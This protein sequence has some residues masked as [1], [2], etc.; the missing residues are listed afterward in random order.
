MRPKASQTVWG[1]RSKCGLH[2]SHH[3]LLLEGFS[4]VSFLKKSSYSRLSNSR[5]FPTPLKLPD[6]SVVHRHVS[7]RVFPLNH[8][9][10]TRKGNER[11]NKTLE[12]LP[13]FIFYVD[14]IGTGTERAPHDSHGAVQ[15]WPLKTHRSAVSPAA[16]LEKLG[17]LWEQDSA[18]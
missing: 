12:K 3:S 6:Q 13:F 14:L 1:F 4:L 18:P 2:G 16:L 11:V 7:H 9:L 17:R 10:I 15:T 5:N 8:K